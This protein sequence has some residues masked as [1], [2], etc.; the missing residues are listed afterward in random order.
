MP[1]TILR[2]V[3]GPTNVLQTKPHNTYHFPNDVKSYLQSL[4]T[5]PF[6]SLS[7]IK[8]TSFHKLHLPDGSI[9]FSIHSTTNDLFKIL[10]RD[11][12]TTK[13]SL[14]EY[15]KIPSS[16]N[17]SQQPDMNTIDCELNKENSKI[18][19]NKNMGKN[20]IPNYKYKNKTNKNRSQKW[21]IKNA[22]MINLTMQNM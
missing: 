12:H 5:N 10:Q 6:H 13:D 9:A 3:V 21:H 22:D 16:A 2:P 7:D 4:E 1:M 11:T 14:L 18:H 17:H 8:N 20:N 19:L 15:R